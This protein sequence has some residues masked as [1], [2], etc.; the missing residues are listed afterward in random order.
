MNTCLDF[1]VLSLREIHTVSAPFVLENLPCTSSKVD[2][3]EDAADP[4]RD[5]KHIVKGNNSARVAIWLTADLEIDQAGTLVEI[6]V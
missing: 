5:M 4:A 1:S 6:G 3:R 2:I